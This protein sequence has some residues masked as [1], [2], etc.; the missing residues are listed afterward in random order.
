MRGVK[1]K[2]RRK[3]WANSETSLDA[4]FYSFLF[5]SNLFVVLFANPDWFAVRYPL[6]PTSLSVIRY[7]RLFFVYPLRSSKLFIFP[8]HYP[9]SSTRMLSIIPDWFRNVIRYARQILGQSWRYPLSPTNLFIHLKKSVR[10]E[11]LGRNSARSTL[12]C[13]SVCIVALRDRKGMFASSI[14]S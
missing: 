10:N 9:L 1:M 13:A 4:D 6:C 2:E 14:W 7:A 8:M 3:R 5:S 11:P 12:H